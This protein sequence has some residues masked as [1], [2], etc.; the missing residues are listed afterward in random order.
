MINYEKLYFHLFNEITDAL[1][2][3]ENQNFG[4]ASV[5]LKE[6]QMSTESLYVDDINE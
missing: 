1:K 6:A 4:N 2:E 5:I 3:I